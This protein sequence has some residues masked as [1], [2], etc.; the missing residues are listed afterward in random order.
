MA[1]PRSFLV[2]IISSANILFTPSSIIIAQAQLAPQE[3]SAIAKAITVRIDGVSEG[4]GVI[5]DNSDDTYSVITNWHVVK[6]LG[7]YTVQTYDGQKHS[8]DYRQTQEFSESTDLAIIKFTSENDYEVSTLGDSE[9]L[10]EGQ[11]IHL[12]GYPG[13]DQIIGENDRFYRFNSLSINAILPDSREG[14]YSLAYGGENFSGMSGSPILNSNGEVIGINGTAYV[15]VDGKA[16]ANYAIPIH[17]YQELAA[18]IDTFVINKLDPVTVFTIAD[19]QGA[20]LVA[21]REDDKKVAGVFISQNDANE[22]VNQLKTEN[23]ELAAKVRVVPVSLG[24]VYKL[25]ESAQSQENALNFAYVPEEEAVNS[26]KI[27]G[28]ENQQPYQGGVPLFVARGGE[29]KDY[30]TFERDGKQVIPFFFEKA[31]LDEMVAKFQEQEPEIAANVDIEVHPLE[32]LIETLATSSDEILEKIVLV[33][34]SESIEFLE[35]VSQK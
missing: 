1:I 17:I 28:E 14:G 32:G 20:P 5:I 22:F 21:S 7:N 4:S 12:A 16:R 29:G 13:S 34:S 6:V 27:I 9:A 35:N 31:Q 15:D 33:P 19:A 2:G 23:P 3:V 18:S 26:A 30:L 24:E 10:G 25:S 11:T 8:V